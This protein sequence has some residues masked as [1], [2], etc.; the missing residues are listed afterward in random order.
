MNAASVAGGFARIAALAVVLVA[1]AVLGL[2]VGTALNERSD[3]AQTVNGYPPGWQGGA[4]IPLSR[5]AAPTSDGAIDWFR[6]HPEFRQ[7][8]V[9]GDDVQRHPGLR[10]QA[11]DEPEDVDAAPRG[12]PA[13]VE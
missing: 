8:A 1:A 3:E 6:L 12:I 7:D 9:A 5:A 11:S 10:R 2:A 4:A 13:F